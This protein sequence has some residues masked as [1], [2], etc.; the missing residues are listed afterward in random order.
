MLELM[1]GLVNNYCAAD[2]RRRNKQLITL[3]SASSLHRQLGDYDL[4]F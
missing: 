3:L 1:A 2:P 4:Q